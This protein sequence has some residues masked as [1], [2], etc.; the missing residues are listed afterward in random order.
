MCLKMGPICL[1]SE[2]QRQRAFP[3]FADLHFVPALGLLLVSCFRKM[4]A[5]DFDVFT[6]PPSTC[7]RSLYRA[8]V[9]GGRRG[10]HL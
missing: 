2:R 9:G 8:C 5:V 1:Q 3:F 10:L 4:P 7:S 6:R